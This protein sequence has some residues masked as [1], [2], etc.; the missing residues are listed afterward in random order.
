LS[1]LAAR[2]A[3]FHARMGQVD[4]LTPRDLTPDERLIRARLVMEETA[5]LIVALVGFRESLALA[6]EM[7]FRCKHKRGRDPGDL[8]EIADAVIDTHVVCAGTLV[9]AGVQD[10]DLIDLV[11]DANDAKVGGGRDEHGKFRK[12]SGWEPPRIREELIRQGWRP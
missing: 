3:T 7:I 4:P 11:C 2:V 9:A 12:P 8:A 1:Y 6:D 10:K 5:E